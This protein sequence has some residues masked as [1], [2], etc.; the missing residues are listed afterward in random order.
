MVLV[1]LLD[2]VSQLDRAL[3]HF[4]QHQHL[5]L[6]PFSLG[7]QAWQ[8]VLEGLSLPMCTLLCVHM[9]GEVMLYWYMDMW[10]TSNI[11]LYLDRYMYEHAVNTLSMHTLNPSHWYIPHTHCSCSIVIALQLVHTCGPIRPVSP[12]MPFGPR[13]PGGPDAPNGPV[14]PRSPLGP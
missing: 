9:R 1:V 12:C 3:H 7:L 11:T 5:L 6:L 8:V 14:G 13:K 10:T 4:L 2:Q